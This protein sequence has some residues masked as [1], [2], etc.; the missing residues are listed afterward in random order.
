MLMLVANSAPPTSPVN[1]MA[2]KGP[3]AATKARSSA[4]CT[5]EQTANSEFATS[6]NIRA[7]S[8]KVKALPEPSRQA[9]APIS[10][11]H[12]RG[13]PVRCRAAVRW[14]WGRAFPN[15]AAG[16]ARVR[17]GIRAYAVLGIGTN[18]EPT[19]YLPKLEPSLIDGGVPVRFP[20]RQSKGPLSRLLSRVGG[21]IGGD[22]LGFV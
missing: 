10:R 6:I 4:S 1:L 16:A 5:P 9:A 17:F 20:V 15:G 12:D 11:A 8:R 13:W 21:H 22:R 18:P 3:R 14:R 2:A 7:V 19:P